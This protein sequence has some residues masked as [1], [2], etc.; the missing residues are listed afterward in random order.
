MWGWNESMWFAIFAGV[1]LKSTAVLGVAWLAALLLRGP[2]IFYPS[3]PSL[4]LPIS[5]VAPCWPLTVGCRGFRGH[6]N[7]H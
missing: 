2:T 1:A 6:E 5:S 3:T 7:L 4:L